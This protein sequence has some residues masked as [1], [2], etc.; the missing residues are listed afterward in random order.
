MKTKF[1]LWKVFCFILLT[2]GIIFVTKP[3]WIF[4]QSDKIEQNYYLGILLALSSGLSASVTCVTI[5]LIDKEKADTSIL[6][7]YT[8]LSQII[9]CCFLTLLDENDLILSGNGL[10]ISRRNWCLM[11]LSAFFYILATCSRIRSNQMIAPS[12]V[13]FIRSSEITLALIAQFVFFDDV[14]NVLSIIGSF[15]V[16]LSV[17]AKVVEDKMIPILPNALVKYI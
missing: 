15:L 3:T 11:L 8:G 10:E 9:C 12:L 13:S 6:V 17:F 14:P 7:V 16:I 4:D 5:G 1:G 2:I